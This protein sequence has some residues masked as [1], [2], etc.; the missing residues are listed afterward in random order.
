M[1]IKDFTIAEFKTLIRETIAEVLQ[2]FLLDPDENQPVKEEVKQQLLQMRQ[3]RK[4]GKVAIPAAEVM[5]R[6]EL[7]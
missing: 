6:L 7:N 5:K 1:Q 2:D 3:R 4:A